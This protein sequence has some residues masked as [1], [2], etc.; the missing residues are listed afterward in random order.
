MSL[1]LHLSALLLTAISSAAAQ[2]APLYKVTRLSEAAGTAWVTDLNNAGQAIGAAGDSRYL[3]TAAGATR[4]DDNFYMTSINGHGA[5]VGTL[6]DRTTG[7]YEGVKYQNGMYTRLGTLTQ[8]PPQSSAD[9]INDSGVIVGWSR[10][11]DTFSGQTVRFDAN[12]P[13]SLNL[14]LE[15]SSPK[16]IN[17][18]GTIVGTY[19]YEDP[20]NA[21]FVERTFLYQDGKLSSLPLMGND[22]VVGSA[23]NNANTVVGGI[24]YYQSGVRTPF[25]YANGVVTPLAIPG[26]IH[27]WA[28]D[29]NNAGQVVGGFGD[30]T[31]FDHAFLFDGATSYDIDSLLV[32]GTGL[33]IKSA[34]S[35]N[36]MGQIGGQGCD[37]A[38]NCFAVLLTPVPEPQTWGMWLAGVGLIGWTARRKSSVGG[39]HA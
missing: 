24:D 18:A 35:I 32:P 6:F 36:D 28:N 22:D 10:Y 26:G 39:S 17:A 4:L 20:R 19:N 27:G 25:L 5:V 3:W 15:A 1:R 23:I 9:A 14:P 11:E 2:A 38:G 16:G 12:G 31:Q 21:I 29:I 33:A 8:N 34:R 30:S 37:T 13:V 7:N